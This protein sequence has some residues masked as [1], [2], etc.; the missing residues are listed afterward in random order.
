MSWGEGGRF[1]QESPCRGSGR[2]E[3]GVDP[4][5]PQDA[6]VHRIIL[7]PRVHD[8]V[9]LGCC[10]TCGVEDESLRLW[11]CSLIYRRRCYLAQPTHQNSTMN[12]PVH[13]AISVVQNC[14]WYACNPR[15]RIKPGGATRRYRESRKNALMLPTEHR[16]H[17]IVMLH[18]DFVLE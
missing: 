5:P 11:T 8:N 6:R 15:A 12:N 4:P 1:F 17:V 18:F 9:M 14:T 3:G 7:Y 10:S 13:C 16:S 2:G